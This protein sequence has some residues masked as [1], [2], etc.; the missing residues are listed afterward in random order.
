M[1]A[2]AKMNT[3]LGYIYNHPNQTKIII[4]I[5][6]EQLIKLIENA[7]KIEAEVR[8]RKA[9]GENRLIKVVGG[10][11]KILSSESEILLTLYYL[12]NILTFQLLAINFGVSESTANNIFHYWVD[13]FRGF[14]PASLLEQVKKKESDEFWD[15]EIL[16]ELK[17]IVDRT[18]QERERPRHK[19]KQKKY[20]TG[21]NA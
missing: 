10:R 12:H 6:Y 15:K 18:E 19:K 16:K 21:K 4:G 9:V 20:Y 2:I 5:S 13:I 14:L 8:Y 17:L 1:Y 3:I 7:Q 11:K